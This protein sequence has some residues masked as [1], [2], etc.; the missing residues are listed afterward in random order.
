MD[1]PAPAKEIDKLN[2]DT[3]P[4]ETPVVSSVSEDKSVDSTAVI[5]KKNE[6]KE[7][8]SATKIVEL[9]NSKKY[10][11]SIKEKR[12]KPLLVLSLGIK[13]KKKSKN[14]HKAV[15]KVASPKNNKKQMTQ[16]GML[17]L[18]VLSLIIAVD[19]GWLN[20]GFDLPFSFFGN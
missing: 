17:A 10:N 16:V 9:I 5:D 14:G 6:T 3:E 2:A 8:D 20:L 13:K 7:D 1:I 11:L 4:T 19:I 18:L 12:T 15:K